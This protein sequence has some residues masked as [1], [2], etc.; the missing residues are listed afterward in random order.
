MIASFV[1]GGIVA[2]TAFVGLL[3]IVEAKYTLYIFTFLRKLK[4]RRLRCFVDVL[5]LLDSPCAITLLTLWGFP[6]LA[7]SNY[8]VSS[9]DPVVELGLITKIKS[10]RL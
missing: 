7:Q 3:W 10:T 2:E 1:N 8:R 4:R 9:L 6:P 5:D